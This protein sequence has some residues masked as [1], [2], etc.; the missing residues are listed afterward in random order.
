MFAFCPAINHQKCGIQGG[1]GSSTDMSLKA[2]L[3]K[4]EVQATGMRYKKASFADLSREYD[5]CY[6]E[7]TMD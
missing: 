7:V 1:S 6:Y 5:A 2:G 3:N 4:V